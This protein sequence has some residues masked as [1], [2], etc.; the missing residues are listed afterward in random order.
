MLHE[1]PERFGTKNSARIM[2]LQL[3]L[4]YTGT[5]CLPPLLGFLAD[6]FSLIIFPYLLFLFGLVLLFSTMALEKMVKN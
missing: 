6:Q 2:S 1:T 3:A 4:A 5:T